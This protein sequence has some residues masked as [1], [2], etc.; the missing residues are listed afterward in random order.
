MILA[1]FGSILL[2]ILAFLFVLGTIILLHEAGHF[3]FAVKGGILCR[4]YAFGMGPLLFKKKKGETQYSIRAFPIGGFCAIAGETVEDDPLKGKD[5]LRLLIENGKVTKICFEVDLDI[6]SDMPLYDIIEYDLLDKENTGNLYIK[7]KTTDGEDTLAVA[8]DAHYVFS[9]V[10]YKKST[11]DVNEKRKK[12]IDSI[13]IAPFNRQL[14]SKSI[15]R[16]AMVMFGGPLMNMLLAILAFFL[17]FTI[18]GVSNTSTTSL[19][20]VDES[21]PAY[22]SGLRENDIIRGLEYS[23]IDGNLHQNLEM[24]D[25]NDISSFMTDYKNDEKALYAIKIYYTHANDDTLLNTIVLP[26]VFIYSISMY[27]DINSDDVK[28]AP[29]NTSSK[30]YKAG[31][32]EGDIINSIN[33]VAVNNWLDVYRAFKKAENGEEVKVNITREEDGVNKVY[34]YTVKPYSKRLFEKTQEVSYV[35]LQVGISPAITH[36]VFKVLGRTFEKMATS[37]ADLVNTLGMLIFSKEVGLRDLTGV[38]GIFKLTSTAASNGFASVLYLL[39]FLSVNIGFVNLLPIPALDGGRLLFLLIELIRRKP[40][41]E[42]V[43]T[44]AITITMILLYALM[45]YVLVNDVLRIF[46]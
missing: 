29:L 36:N 37:I 10:G 43:Q 9:K 11:K 24:K 34:D 14:N 44:R 40:V 35:D 32:R 22:V 18:S 42:K 7:V 46:G 8:N 33:D 12:Y 19:Y 25:W 5:K 28:I 31:L 45:I 15:G 23:D 27:E 13:Q 1:S 6:F 38:V 30:A 41:S 26:Q 4:E 16:R 21:T 39:G 3:F 17:A 20:I 2:S